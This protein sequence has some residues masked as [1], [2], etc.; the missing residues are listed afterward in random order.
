MKYKK[1][2][3]LLAMLLMIGYACNKDKLNEPTLGFFV[4]DTVANKKGVGELLIGA[5]SL[6]DGES[7]SNITYGS[8][9]SNWI[10]GSICGSEAYKGGDGR[11]VD[12]PDINSLE[13]FDVNPFNSDLAQKWAAVY[14]GIARSNDV[15]R[16]MRKATDMSPAD[17]IEVTAEACFLRGFYHMEAKKMWNKIP[18]IDESITIEAGNYHVKNDTSWLRIENDL[19]YAMNN[20]PIKQTAAGRANRYA[21][22]AFLAKA[23]M[24]ESKYHQALLLLQDLISQGVTA[25]GEKYALQKHYHDNFDPIAKNSSESVFAAQ[26][27]V[28]D[29]ANSSGDGSN[30]NLGDF[31]N[32]PLIISYGFFQPS[33][34]LVNHFKTDPTSGLPDLAHFNDLDVTNDEGYTSDSTFIPYTGTLDPRLDWTVGRRGIPYLDWG[35]H[36]GM[37]WISN[38]SYGGPYS[39]IKNAVAQNENG[40]YTESGWGGPALTANN[41]NLLRFADILLWDAEAQIEVGSVDS[42]RYFVNL[43][44]QRITDSSGWVHTY[45]DPANPTKGFTN[46]P[47]ANYHIGLYTIPWTDPDYARLAVHYERILEFG[48]EGHRF[49]DLVRWGI[50]DTEI[51]QYFLNEKLKRRYLSDASFKKG[52]NEYFP[53][54]LVQIELSAGANGQKE[55]TQNPGY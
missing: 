45:I 27:S 1:Y 55:M 21:A 15:I 32:F 47:A 28:N 54:P 41:V 20:L 5:Y 42:A 43:I 30:S 17:T 31:L 11:D 16:T 53:I 10:Y 9:A 49:F 23:Y 50:A 40:V 8:A 19:V 26:M 24:F 48:M 4:Q 39:P 44:R 13:T 25:K 38:Q 29:G 12:Q 46:T 2:F 37:A 6:L 18:Y 33:Q 3:S 52:R 51:N 36:P 7:G 34:Y 22:E 35:V 14:D